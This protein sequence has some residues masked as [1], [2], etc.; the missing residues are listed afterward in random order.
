MKLVDAIPLRH[1]VRFFLPQPIEEEKLAII[2]KEIEDIGRRHK[3]EMRLH[4]GERNLFANMLSFFCNFR[5]VKTFIIVSATDMEKAGYYGE[6]IVLLA[7]TLGLNTCWVGQTYNR[8]EIRKQY[9]IAPTAVIAIGY[10][11]TQGKPHKSKSYSDVCDVEN[12]P[13]WF[14]HG[15]DAA[16]LAPTAMNKQDFRIT[17]SEKNRPVFTVG[18]S[19][20]G[21]LNLGIIKCNFDIAAAEYGYRQ[22]K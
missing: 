15:V 22:E 3:V 7:Q 20:F 1:S 18:K 12:P 14:K 13:L 17:L 8:K 5:N 4:T 16:L 10:G 21:D 19:R 2:K 6:R 11:A 9:N